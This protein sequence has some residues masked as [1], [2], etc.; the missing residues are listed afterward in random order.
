MGLGVPFNIA[1]ASLLI[2]IFAKICN[3]IP[4]D[5]IHTIND[6]H[7]YNNHINQLQEQIKRNPL[8]FPKLVISNRGQETVEDFI[9][10]DFTLQGYI[11]H[12]PVRMDMAT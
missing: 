9:P 6:A 10:G 2:H 1:S 3:L 12:P 5:L 11:C 7:V 8:P 4:G